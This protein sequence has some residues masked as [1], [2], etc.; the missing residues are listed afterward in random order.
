MPTP[1]S[2]NSNVISNPQLVEYGKFVQLVGDT[3]FPAVSVLDLEYPDRTLAFPGNSAAPALS[4]YN[5]Y[6]KY[7]VITYEANTLGSGGFA[8]LSAGGYLVGN[9]SAILPIATT[10]LAGMTAQYTQNNILAGVSL[11][12]GVRIDA[13][14]TAVSASSTASAIVYYAD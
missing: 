6:P 10:I 4:T 8:Y 7:A 1:P 9:F 13:P 3:R 5:V 11:P 12:A 2:V 14:F